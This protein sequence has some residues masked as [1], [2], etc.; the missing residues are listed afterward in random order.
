MDLDYLLR[1]LLEGSGRPDRGLVRR[2]ASTSSTELR[3]HGSIEDQ[4]VLHALTFILSTHPAHD[5]ASAMRSVLLLTTIALVSCSGPRGGLGRDEEPRWV[6]HRGDSAHAPE[7]TLAAVQSAL[8]LSPT[9]E[10]IEV[11]VHSSGDGE[12][13][14]IHDATLDR[15][16][17]STG[18]VAAMLWSDLS[19]VDAGYPDRFGDGF[20]GER[21]PRLADVLD[22][23]E[24]METGVMIEVKSA[25]SGGPAAAL[26][27]SRGEEH[28]HVLA[29][30]KPDVLVAASLEAPG[31]ETLFLVDKPDVEHIELARQIGAGILGVE[32][33]A[34]NEEL[35]AR[36]REAG[37]FLW[38]WTVDEP[39]R[40][41][42]LDAL[43]VD[44]VIS[45]DLGRVRPALHDLRSGS[46]MR[47]EPRSR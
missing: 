14:V 11:D 38:V 17:R 26:V 19:V 16:S 12:L 31:L 35:V 34:V 20:R 8:G 47:S 45:N 4:H 32:H 24:G 36:V 43:G 42:E 6:A 18:R 2:D 22:V 13:I 5:P 3:A 1:V 15:T 44:G 21:L 28:R 46:A 29:S 41:R 25:G 40:V 27:R 30:F 10:W 23:V 7:N 39:G 33:K 37:L 9:P